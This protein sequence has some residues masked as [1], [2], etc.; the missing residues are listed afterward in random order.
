MLGEIIKSYREFFRI[1]QY[2]FAVFCGVSVNTVISVENGE[3]SSC[4]GDVACIC[5]KL[6]TAPTKF[7]RFLNI[8]QQEY[9]LKMQLG[10]LP[11]NLRMMLLNEL[12]E[13]LSSYIKIYTQPN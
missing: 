12:E 13:K 10:F 8:E 1:T 6:V 3:N 9:F 11:E 4:S 2:E 5:K 7:I